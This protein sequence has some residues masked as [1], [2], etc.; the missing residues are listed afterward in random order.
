AYPPARPGR[1]WV[2]ALVLPEP[3]GR[4][5]A[6]HGRPIRYAYVERDWPLAAYQNAYAIEPGSAEMPSAGRALTAELITSLVARGVAVA[7]VVLH[8]GVSS[9]EA[10]EAPYPERFRVPGATARLVNATRAGG[11]RVVA[12]GTT[13]VRA[14]ETVADDRCRAHAGEGWTELFVTPVR[15]VR[16]VDG[17]LTGWHPPEASH[18]ALLESVAGAG[19][20]AA[21]YRAATEAGYLWHEFGDLHL[22]LP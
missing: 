4:Y 2:A 21:A 6:R 16:L 8:T 11:G 5:L 10:G 18:V 22:V 19:L 9:L 14:L 13:V 15:G 17:L 1:L 12:V 3:L 20:L 7:P